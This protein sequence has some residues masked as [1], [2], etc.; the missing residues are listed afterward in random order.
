M[1]RIDSV[2]ALAGGFALAFVRFKGFLY[3]STFRRAR[4]PVNPKA[5]FGWWRYL[6]QV[7]LT[8]SSRNAQ[9]AGLLLGCRLR[10]RFSRL[11]F[12]G[13]EAA[14]S[15]LMPEVTVKLMENS[16]F[17]RHLSLSVLAR[18]PACG[19]FSRHDL[20]T[21][22]RTCT[23]LVRRSRTLAPASVGSVGSPGTELEF[24]L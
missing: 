20:G 10:L 8:I 21:T 6:P 19:T 24:A 17:G 18:Q 1:G 22:P 9:N 7:P 23:L 4:V 11:P 3:P 14:G 15:Y 5:P 2:R 16:P 13:Y 12:L